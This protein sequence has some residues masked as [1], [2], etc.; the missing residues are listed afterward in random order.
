[1]KDFWR[2]S[3]VDTLANQRMVTR[4][5]TA[6]MEMRGWA[7][8]TTLALSIWETLKVEVELTTAHG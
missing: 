2:S 7:S 3:D 5:Q 1:M 4:M 6:L 8:Y